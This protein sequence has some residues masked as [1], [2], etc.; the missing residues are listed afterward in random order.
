MA[1]GAVLGQQP[2]HDDLTVLLGARV[3]A[4]APIQLV[5]HPLWQRPFVRLDGRHVF[6]VPSHVVGEG[7]GQ[8]LLERLAALDALGGEAKSCSLKTGSRG[9]MDIAS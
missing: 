2:S 8:L 4:L 3:L 1:P 7:L 6:G 9:A 5:G